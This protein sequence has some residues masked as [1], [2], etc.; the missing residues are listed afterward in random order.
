MYNNTI[1]SIQIF[2]F[3]MDNI[4][5]NSENNKTSDPNR[6]LLNVENKMNSKIMCY[7]IKY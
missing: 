6:L 3:I 5:I 1:K 4:F 7:I 2:L